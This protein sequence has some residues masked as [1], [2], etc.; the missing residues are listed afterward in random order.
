MRP[1]AR[2]L[3]RHHAAAGRDLDVDLDTSCILCTAP[4]W[5][6]CHVMCV[7]PRPGDLVVLRGVAGRRVRRRRRAGVRLRARCHNNCSRQHPGASA[8]G[9]ERDL[10]SIAGILKV[11]ITLL[12]DNRESVTSYQAR[13]N[14]SYLLIGLK[15]HCSPMNIKIEETFS[16][17]R[18]SSIYFYTSD[19]TMKYVHCTLIY[20][21]YLSFRCRIIF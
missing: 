1:G 11:T 15:I 13:A 14:T 7:Q 17:R 2:P 20:C 21:E 9:L 8:S 4:A 6:C 12:I 18:I 19:K 5:R 16:F 10:A 3:H